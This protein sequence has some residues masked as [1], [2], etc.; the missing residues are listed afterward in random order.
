MYV[1]ENSFMADTNLVDTTLAIPPHEARSAG[2]RFW[3]FAGRPQSLS[4]PE[5]ESTAQPISRVPET[6][7]SRW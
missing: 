6:A 7:H 3:A 4:K 2:M 5:V 1:K